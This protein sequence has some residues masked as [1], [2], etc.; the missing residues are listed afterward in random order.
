MIKEY[1]DSLDYQAVEK[2]NQDIEKYGNNYKI[3]G[4]QVFDYVTYILV[5]WITA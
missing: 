3:V 4:Y 2:L 1:I 5:E